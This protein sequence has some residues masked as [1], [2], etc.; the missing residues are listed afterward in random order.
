MRFLRASADGGAGDDLLNGN[1][2]SD[3]LKGG[4]EC[5]PG[6]RNAQ[7]QRMQLLVLGLAGCVVLAVSVRMARVSSRS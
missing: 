5:A 2:G 7:G 3:L 4:G 1:E 6:D